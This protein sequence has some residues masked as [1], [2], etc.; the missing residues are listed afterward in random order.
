MVNEI[1][2]TQTPVTARPDEQIAAPKAA[3]K[4]PAATARKAIARKRSSAGTVTKKTTVAKKPSAAKTTTQKE[5]KV[6]ESGVKAIRKRLEVSAE[7]G[8]ELFKVITYAQ[9][10]LYGKFY[11]DVDNLIEK[12]RQ[13]LPKQFDSLVKRGA[14]LEEDALTFKKGVSTKIK[15]YDVKGE[16]TG[17]LRKKTENIRDIYQHA[18]GKFKSFGRKAA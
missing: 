14:K 3:V 8:T 17:L 2:E 6:L 11:D 18:L 5:L 10:G 16:A 13:E 15:A 12:Q 7:K 9:L 1:S 4:K